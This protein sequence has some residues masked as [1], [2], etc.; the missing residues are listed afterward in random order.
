M[1]TF[2]PVN[3]DQ[4]YLLPPSV[5]DWLPSN[6]L[7]HFVV[8]VVDQ[9]DLSAIESQY[10]NVGNAAYSPR[11][12]V[13]LLFLG[14]ATR[15]LSSRQ[16]ERATYES[17]AFR[18]IA[19]NTHPDH[20]TIAH[21]RSRFHRELA[22]LFAQILQYAQRSGLLKLGTVSLD[23]TKVKANASKHKALS[24]QHA[25]LLEKQIEE[26]VK[27][28]LA[29]AEAAD[30]ADVPDGMNLPE[31]LSRRGDRIKKIRDAKEEM[32]RRAQERYEAEQAEYERKMA[33]REKKAQDTGKKPGGKP[34]QPPVPGPRPKDQVNLT[35]RESRIMPKGKNHFEQ[36]YNGQAGVDTESRLIVGQR[37]TQNTNDKEELTPMLDQ[38]VQLPPEFG[39]VKLLLCDA[40]YFSEANIK[41]CIAAGVSPLIAKNRERH[42]Q[43]ALERFS[44]PKEPPP[45]IKADPVG[46]MLH[47]LKTMD[48]K[49]L[50]GLRKSTVEPV[51]GIIKSIL[52]LQQFSLRGVAKVASEWAI[53]CTAY[54][55]KRLH[56]M[57][58]SRPAETQ[59]MMTC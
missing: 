39:K 50:Y 23:G 7:A 13:A 47:R 56:T 25:E 54:N 26:Q 14:Y 53:A 19:G 9:L 45:C 24:H 49:S 33:A 59:K 36:A 48:G 10:R 43:S 58:T 17:V 1:A 46:H 38:L 30:Q 52:G 18:F 20:D 16:L 35:D 12:L 22:D 11:M 42:N 4:L 8:E 27:E 55:I 51:F 15:T 29:L 3:R 5:Q 57:V 32:E 21:F 6:H 44:E 37:I 31:E 41:A 34:P 2:K 28:L 40:G